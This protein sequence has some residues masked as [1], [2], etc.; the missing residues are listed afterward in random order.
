MKF[1]AS[2][3]TLLV[4]LASIQAAETPI[5]KGEAVMVADKLSQAEP[6]ELDQVHLLE[7][8]F[9]RA[10]EADREYLMKLDLDLMLYPF[11]REA[12]IPSPVKGSDELRFDFTGHY[13]GHYLSA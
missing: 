7:G 6:F 4:P 2:L 3:I 10:Q 11:R 8:P 9:K 13:L 1:S 12:K 5:V